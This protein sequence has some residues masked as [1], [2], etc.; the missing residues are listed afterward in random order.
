MKD[1]RHPNF[2]LGLVSLFLLFIGVGLKAN[3]YRSGDFVLLAA[4]VMGGIHWIWSIV[5]VFKDY[6]ATQETENKNII[7]VILVVLIP[8]VGGL[9]YYAFG[10]TIKI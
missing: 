1:S 8:P 9:L 6:R 5:D 3:G 7:W 4:I 10:R 2:I